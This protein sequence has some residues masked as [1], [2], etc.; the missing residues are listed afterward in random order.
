MFSKATYLFGCN[1]YCRVFLTA[2]FNKSRA[3]LGTGPSDTGEGLNGFCFTL[4]SLQVSSA[5]QKCHIRD[6]NLDSPTADRGSLLS[7]GNLQSVQWS[8]NDFSQLLTYFLHSLALC[9]GQGA[10]KLSKIWKGLASQSVGWLQIAV[11]TAAGSKS[12]KRKTFGRHLL[13]QLQFQ[14]RRRPLVYIGLLKEACSNICRSM[15]CVNTRT[16]FPAKSRVGG[17]SKQGTFHL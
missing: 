16:R 12:P 6:V 15:L 3:I 4:C 11:H 2:Q 10:K 1:S 9:S 5:L 13:P 8:I 17:S 7:T 14:N